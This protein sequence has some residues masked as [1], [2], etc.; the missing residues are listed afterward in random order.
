[1][2]YGYFDLLI[3][4]FERCNGPKR[5]NCANFSADIQDGRTI[6]YDMNV[7]ENVKPSKGKIV[8]MANQKQLVRLQMDHPCEHLFL[9]PIMFMILNVTQNCVISKGRYTSVVDIEKIAQAYY[10]GK[11][12]YG[13]ITFI[14]TFYNN[15]C[16]LSCAK[17]KVIFSPKDKAT[18][19]SKK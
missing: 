3:T 4:K 18:G 9:K 16:N 10:G 17:V 1:M 6:L 19:T 12:F 14:A 11:F 8:V 7:T 15:K 5:L 2:D 13:T